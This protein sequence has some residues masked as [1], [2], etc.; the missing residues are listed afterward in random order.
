LR[1][2]SFRPAFRASLEVLPWSDT[3]S[4]LGLRPEGRMCRARSTSFCE[5][6]HATLA[7]LTQ[8]VVDMIASTAPSAAPGEISCQVHDVDFDDGQSVALVKVAG[9]LHYHTSDELRAE[10]VEP[11]GAGAQ[12]VLVDLSGVRSV[13]SAGLATLVL[14]TQ[15]AA[16][17]HA[18]SALTLTAVPSRIKDTIEDLGYAEL[19]KVA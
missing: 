2:G 14:V 5:A 7:R 11:I 3:R 6:A 17:Q 9:D 16:R 19:L 18:D 1:S 8:M 12:R 13:D 10:V 15:V 4:Q